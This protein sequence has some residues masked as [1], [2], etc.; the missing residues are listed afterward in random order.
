[1]RFLVDAQLPVALARW[2][3]AK[4]YDSV[5]VADIGLARASDSEIWNFAI[6][7]DLVIITK[8]EDFPRRTILSKTNPRI[9]WI[10]LAN[11]RK[12]TLLMWF[13]SALPKI[14]NLLQRGERL[15]EVI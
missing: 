4:G 1:M 3:T 9:V 13:E 10:R 2:L 7:R 5:H 14:V 8:D 11:S 12:Q 15:I 6:S